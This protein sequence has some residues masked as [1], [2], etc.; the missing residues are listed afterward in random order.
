MTSRNRLNVHIYPSTFRFE[1]RML[2]TT[3]SALD[4]GAI[5]LV[6]M[7]RPLALDPDLPRKLLA[8]E[9]GRPLPSYALPSVLG[10]AGESEW[11]EH[12]I[13]RLG[14]GREPD[15][16]TRAVTAAAAF[17]TGE[18]RRGLAEGRRRRRLAAS[19]G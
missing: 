10:L 16:R 13:G 1:S 17:V 6:G 2:K 19:S 7:G 15:P 8:G 18:A 3:R 5:D 9:D 14:D 11:Y 12:Q 4:S